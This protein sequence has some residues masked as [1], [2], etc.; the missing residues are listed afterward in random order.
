MKNL[1]FIYLLFY[2]AALN[3][4]DTI[5]LK[6]GECF[7]VKLLEINISD[8]KCKKSDYLS[9]PDYTF[10]KADLT[11]IKYGNGQTDTIR[12][13]KT[14]VITTE[15]GPELS[16]KPSVT[17]LY[18][19]GK[20][21]IDHE[22]VSSDEFLYLCQN[23]LSSERFYQTKELI[24]KSIVRKKLQIGLGVGAVPLYFAGALSMLLGGI[25]YA[26]SPNSQ[27]SNAFFTVGGI[28]ILGGISL[29]VTSSVQKGISLKYKS[30]AV[31]LYNNTH[32]SR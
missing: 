21:W 16:K 17:V 8:I 5:C 12:Q 19:R 30:A 2:Y 1:I 11:Y 24:D 26:Y 18:K 3:A 15:T 27:E 10:N 23:T 4:Q 13:E 29:S 32:L 20:I 6:T 22:A 7:G 14:A 28:S 25:T 9:G 31:N